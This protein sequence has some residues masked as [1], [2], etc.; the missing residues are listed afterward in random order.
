MRKEDGDGYITNLA[1]LRPTGVLVRYLPILRIVL[2][3]IGIPLIF[4]ACI[5]SKNEDKT[6]SSDE[7][8][9]AEYTGL[10]SPIIS[11]MELYNANKAEFKRFSDFVADF[12]EVYGDLH[13]CEF[14]Y[15]YEDTDSTV[16]GSGE[17]HVYR[18]KIISGSGTVCGYEITDL[19]VV[20]LL[21]I[22]KAIEFVWKCGFESNDTGGHLSYGEVLYKDFDGIR[23]P[24][25]M[26]CYRVNGC[27]YGKTDNY[28]R[29]EITDFKLLE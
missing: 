13:T 17:W 27:D 25:S 2:L 10:Y 6:A 11:D 3:M 14:S 23:L 12:E 22:F 15:I 7:G 26:T 16:N 20:S 28:L 1:L 9:D 18:W 24:Y 19:L 5:H 8:G 4:M 21:N 29:Y